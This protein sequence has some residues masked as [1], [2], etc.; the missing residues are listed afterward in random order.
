MFIIFCLDFFSL[1]LGRKL[2]NLKF[3]FLIQMNK[4]NKLIGFDIKWELKPI[5]KFYDIFKRHILLQTNEKI[6]KYVCQL[7]KKEIVS[8]INIFLGLLTIK[9]RN[10]I[11]ITFAITNVNDGLEIF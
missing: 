1:F 2:D 6:D 9:E 7:E 11:L 8:Q 4:L 5:E 10:D 3:N